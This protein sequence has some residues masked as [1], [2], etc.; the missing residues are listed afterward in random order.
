MRGDALAAP[1]RAER[2]QKLAGGGAR[3]SEEIR[4]AAT[5]LDQSQQQMLDGDKI[6]VKFLSLSLRRL[7]NVS[8]TVI[9]VGSG[10]PLHV[11]SGLEKFTE[12]GSQPSNVN[13]DPLEEDR[14]K[15]AFLI[16][17]GQ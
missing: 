10:A 11:R 2:L 1:D 12:T 3:L 13:P 6:V 5:T 4:R 8:E 17:E 9:D 7:Q 15:S 14:G 16:Q